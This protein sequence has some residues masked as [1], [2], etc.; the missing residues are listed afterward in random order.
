[1]IEDGEY[2]LALKSGTGAL[3]CHAI[4]KFAVSIEAFFDEKENLHAIRKLLEN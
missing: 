4:A 2:S 1:V 3:K